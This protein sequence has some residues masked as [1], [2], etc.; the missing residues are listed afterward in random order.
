[1]ALLGQ[2]LVNFAPVE[3][4]DFAAKP[5]PAAQ[6]APDLEFA[7]AA[8]PDLAADPVPGSEFDSVQ[9]TVPAEAGTLSEHL[10]TKASEQT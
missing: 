9:W 4:F 2:E 6:L 7:F 10:H 1:L 3:S 5:D 8:D